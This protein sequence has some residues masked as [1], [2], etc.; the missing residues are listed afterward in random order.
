ME[1]KRNVHELL[2]SKTVGKRSLEAKSANTGNERNGV[3][4]DWTQAANNRQQ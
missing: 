2:V 1:D 4:A 3:C